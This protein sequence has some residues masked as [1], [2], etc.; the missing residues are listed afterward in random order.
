MKLRW[1]RTLSAVSLITA[2]LMGMFTFSA[3]AVETTA[4]DAT[5]TFSDSGVTAAGDSGYKIEGTDLTINAAGTYLITGSCADG[6]ITV[7]KGTTGATLILQDLTLTSSE[8]AP[9][10]CNKETE[11]VL[12]ATGTNTLTDAEDPADEESTDEAVADAFDGAAIKVK[13]GASLTITGT[14][15]LTADGTA[16]KNGIKGGSEASIIVD[17]DL[18]LNAK[19]ANTALASDGSVEIK[20]GTVNITAENDGIKSEPDE[21]DTA[22]AGTVTISGGTIT[23]D[24][25]DDA[26]HSTNALTV[27]GGTIVINAGDDALHSEYDVIIGTEGALTGPSITVQSCNEGFEGARVFLN[28]GSGTITA[29]DDGVNAATDMA[30]SEVAI[31][32]NGGDWYVDAAGDGLDSGGDSTN[33]SG[34]DIHLNGGSVEV[35]GSADSGNSA[36]DFDGQ[37]YADGGTM[38]AVGMNGMAQTPTSGLSVTFGQGG[39]G[40]GFFGGLFGGQS[41]S[42]SI[43]KGSTIEVKDSAGSTL[44]T[45]TGVKSANHVVFTS[46]A[47]KEGETYTLYVNGTQAATA[48]A[49]AGNGQGGMQP[50]QPGGGGQMPGDG[51]EPPAMP[52]EGGQ[53]PGDGTEPPAKPGEGGQQP[54]QPGDTSALPFTDVNSGAW[55]YPSVVYVYQNG[56]MNGMSATTFSPETVLTRAQMVQILYNMEGRPTSGSE[57]FSDV[58]SADWFASAVAWAQK[59][60]LVEGYDATTFGPD[61]ALTRAQAAAIL[62]RYAKYKGESTDGS[63]SLNFSDA[64]S[65][66]SWAEAAMRWCVSSGIL[67][68]MDG[69]L[70][71]NGTATRAQIAAIM[72]R[73]LAA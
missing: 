57:T 25:A 39:M 71:P 65:V 35:Y 55:Y 63:G 34:G 59:T 9:L 36:L 1:K 28:S 66:P 43:T 24:T 32:V 64:S 62:Q 38:L 15:T 40:G 17:G 50:G 14:G 10:S 29:S 47:L 72:S 70:N 23:L 30:V 11:V 20:S 33:N 21:D 52:G 16:C 22:S 42:V 54:A 67:Q 73:Y 31:Y 41:S 6:S 37:C 49:A 12:C 68:G 2:L 60:G 4:A 45:A 53:M 44:Y 46:D 3:G 8:G 61:D 27:T 58:D 56:V 19:A 7:K 48:T 51:S 26:I 69:A 5:F 13:A 18:T